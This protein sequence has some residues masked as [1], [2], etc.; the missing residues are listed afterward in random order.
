MGIAMFRTIGALARNETVA[1]TGGSF[2]FLVLLLLG[3]FLLAKRESLWRTLPPHPAHA[4]KI[5]LLVPG[6]VL[7]TKS[8]AVVVLACPLLSY[9]VVPCTANTCTIWNSIAATD[10]LVASSLSAA[11]SACLEGHV[12]LQA[13]PA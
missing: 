7:L 3:G 4:L 1:S 6:G 9:L 5:A 2:L 12:V 8:E 10:S 13:V 11:W